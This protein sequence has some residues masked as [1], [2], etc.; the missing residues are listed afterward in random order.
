MALHTYRDLRNFKKSLEKFKNNQLDG[1]TDLQRLESSLAIENLFRVINDALENKN[2]KEIAPEIIQQLKDLI[3]NRWDIIQGTDSAY[4]ENNVLAA[5]KIYSA[6]ARELENYENNA[7]KLL[8]PTVMMPTLKV[9]ER[10]INN[11]N[12]HDFVLDDQN[13]SIIEIDECLKRFKNT[14]VL[15]RTSPPDEKPLS[16][17]EAKRV[18]EHSRETKEYVEALIKLRKF[19]QQFASDALQ[20]PNNQLLKRD[21]YSK[22]K[23]YDESNHVFKKRW[24]DFNN[25]SIASEYDNEAKKKKLQELENNVIAAEKSYKESQN[26]CNFQFV[27]H[28][29]GEQ[30][31]KRLSKQLLP[32]LIL[33]LN[34]LDKFQTDDELEYTIFLG[35]LKASPSIENR[36][37][38]LD[39]KNGALCYFGVFEDRIINQ[40]FERLKNIFRLLNPKECITIFNILSYLGFAIMFNSNPSAGWEMLASVLQ[41]L[42]S[43][44]IRLEFLRRGFDLKTGHEDFIWKI[45]S[46]CMGAN[47]QQWMSSKFRSLLLPKLQALLVNSE[48]FKEF[49][50]FYEHDSTILRLLKSIKEVFG[51]KLQEVIKNNDDLLMVVN[52]LSPKEWPELLKLLGTASI[53][54][55]LKLLIGLNGLSPKEWPK[56][57]DS[58]E[59][60]SWGK[61]AVSLKLSKDL[62]KNALKL[63]EIK[64]LKQYPVL[65]D[66]IAKTIID[67][68]NIIHYLKAIPEER[69]EQR[70]ELLKILQPSLGKL[71]NAY[72]VKNIL[73]LLPPENISAFLEIVD[74]RFL[75]EHYPQMTVVSKMQLILEALPL[76]LRYTCFSLLESKKSLSPK[77]FVFKWYTLGEFL[78]LFSPENTKNVLRYFGTSLLASLCKETD[79]N[80]LSCLF[81]KL[82]QKDHLAVR[83]KSAEYLIYLLE[84]LLEYIPQS[85]RKD[86]NWW[87]Q[88]WYEL[89]KQCDNPT[90]KILCNKL[91]TM[92]DE[93]R[94]PPT[95]NRFCDKPNAMT[96]FDQPP[97]NNNEG[98][99]II[100]DKKENDVMIIQQR[101]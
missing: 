78:R 74:W 21:L 86:I 84:Y 89:N 37:E 94:N 55:V 90:F 3:K 95:L 28:H 20:V 97:Q 34:Q 19:K 27:K 44:E 56:F 100:E 63:L 16:T 14:G 76:N 71:L 92:L 99:K 4:T 49:L 52:K 42:P 40:N 82:Q 18:I 77:D 87:R 7:Y 85:K 6:L 62:V 2:D 26:N 41:A 47:R 11:T 17:S 32:N 38:Q 43:D 57:L 101:K 79:V 73:S 64:T 70:F 75:T 98:K 15:M 58:L 22:E 51:L 61:V 67:S 81:S 5:N 72:C 31:D 39:L 69:R 53:G 96:I 80:N 10:R 35:M 91:K 83:E 68:H 50:E 88:N 59:V 36:L 8:M 1:V 33:F 46:I 48:F 93:Y 45:F 60:N 65:K 9:G 66:M 12:T 29:Y 24:V 25:E 54:K 23:K 30:G 13:A